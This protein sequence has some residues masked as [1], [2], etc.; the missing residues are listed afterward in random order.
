MAID[1]NWRF[2]MFT[3]TYVYG[4]IVDEEKT[5]AL[6][7]EIGRYGYRLDEAPRIINGSD[8]LVVVENTTGGATRTEISSSTAPSAGEYRLD[9][10]LDTGF[11]EHH[12]SDD[13]LTFLIDYQAKGTIIVPR[14][15]DDT[16]LADG[17]DLKLS[18]T[19]R[20]EHDGVPVVGYD[21]SGTPMFG[22]WLTGSLGAADFSLA[23]PH[24][25]TDAYTNKKIRGVTGHFDSATDMRQVSDG[26]SHIWPGNTA[27]DN[28]NLTISRF[29]V[30]PNLALTVHAW[31]LYTA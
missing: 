31:I 12:S 8:T 6:D 29:S 15:L 11:V 9:R 14:V 1:A 30:T 20:I 21:S 26:D 2:D 16:T 28:T 22:K 13:T 25:I 19:G 24:G 18:G 23:M 10:T 17:A 7:A 4:T 3:G 27:Y 5:V